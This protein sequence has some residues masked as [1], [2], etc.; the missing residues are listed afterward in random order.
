[1]P[2][3]FSGLKAERKTDMD[4][5]ILRCQYCEEPLV[6]ENDKCEKCGAPVH[7]FDDADFSGDEDI[8]EEAV[9]ETSPK[10]V[11]LI[12]FYYALLLVGP[13][14]FISLQLLRPA[15]KKGA[16]L[17]PLLLPGI[18]SFLILSGACMLAGQWIRGE[19][20]NDAEDPG[21]SGR[22]M[23]WN[24]VVSCLL[25]GLILAGLDYYLGL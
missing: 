7:V 5:S 8:P 11:V 14:A 2:Q 13:G 23:K 18:F 12:G 15:F 19:I 17:K 9:S 25:G 20:K 6:I 1:M 10:S 16:E 21:S 24:A 22:F 4:E 3:K